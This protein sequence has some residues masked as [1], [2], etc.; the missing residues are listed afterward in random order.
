MLTAYADTEAAIASINQIGLDYYL[1]K[2]WDPPELNLY[3]VLDDLLSDW[4]ANVTLPYDGIRVAGTLWSSSSHQVKDFLARNQIPYQ[5]LDID[6]DAETRALVEALNAG[7]YRLP[8]VF[9]PDGTSLIEPANLELAEKVG[10]QTQAGKP[11]YDLIIIGAGPAGLAAAVYGGSEGLQTVMLEKEATGGQAGTSSRIENYLGFPQGLTGVDLARRATSQAQ[12]FGVE[13]LRAIEGVNVRVEDPYRYV[14]L[15]DGAELSSHAIII[16]T[17]VSVR[18]LEVP[19]VSELTGAGVYYGAALTEAAYY[20]GQ[21]VVVVGGANSA[22]QG[23]MFFSRYARMVTM[24]VRASAL[25]LGMSQYLVDQIKATPNIQVILRAEVVEAIGI[26][27]LEALRLCN[28][29]TGEISTLATAAMF[30]FIGAMPHT[31]MVADVVERDS[32]GFLLTGPDLM[33]K[34]IRPKGW[35]LKRDPF[36][37]ETSV[38]GIFAAGDVRHRSVKRVATAVGEGAMAVALV[39]QYLKTV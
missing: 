19:G 4:A 37:L 25:E 20:R 3:P 16:A 14:L 34:G 18:R 30:V 31:E 35:T 21:D 36:F 2:P 12:R 11:F 23:A 32:S 22:G 10:L 13:I 26:D 15:S 27:R 8:V 9:F 1:M 7:A 29:D 24:I 17:G 28:I 5:W 39:H 33:E 38:P 6:T